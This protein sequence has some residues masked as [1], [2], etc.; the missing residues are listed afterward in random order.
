MRLAGQLLVAPLVALGFCVA[1]G[2][3]AFW[4]L[5]SQRSLMNDGAGKSLAVYRLLETANAGVAR[6]N[7]STARAMALI[8]SMSAKD[9]DQLRKSVARGL[10]EA[11][12]H[13]HRAAAADPGDKELAQLSAS[14][15]AGLKKYAKRVDDAIDM[16]SVDANTGVAAL[17]SAETDFVAAAAV[18]AK[19]QAHQQDQVGA[20]MAAAIGLAGTTL[21]VVVIGTLLAAIG[22]VVVALWMSRRIA[23]D[24]RAC[25]DA[26]RTVASGALTVDFGNE[27]NDEIGDL[28]R[29]LRDM[30]AQLRSVVER[31]R[32][33]VDSVH[34]ASRE[35]AQG[36]AD[37][38]ARTEQ[39]A[40]SLQQTAASMEQMTTTVKNNADAARQANQLAA[41]ASEV[42]VKG[43]RAVGDVVSTMTEI[44][45][46]SRKVAEI[47]N[48]I[49]AIAFQTNILALNAAVEAARAGEQG[50]GF[51]VVAAEVRS[52]AQRSAQA[53]HEIKSMI[54]NSVEKVEA[55]SKLVNDAGVTM[56]EIV[57]QVRRVTE[58]IAEISNATLEQSGGIGQVN[59]AITQLEQ[60][61]QQNAALVEQSSAAAQSMREQAGK[62]A[63]AVALF[64][65]QGA[66]AAT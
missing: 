30:V 4:S 48:V 43:G 60:M 47:I 16:A 65:L 21:N 3:V 20:S 61:T 42:A 33:G 40:S 23:G 6:A 2:G 66:A 56:E 58:L 41:S 49:D 55:G 22:S 38:S 32:A 44:S 18:L 1:T 62:L 59:Q 25:S 17:Q 52:L 35:I 37:L 34:T 54:T 46:Q 10:A 53:A 15:T 39:Q 29:A 50:R 27:R 28:A 11:Q 14:F 8:G 45:A 13:V 7:I 51:A 63:E 36:N 5:S 31:V 57:A 24:V 12:D 26:A 64:R 19:A 9:I